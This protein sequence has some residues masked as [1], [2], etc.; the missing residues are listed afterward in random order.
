MAADLSVRFGNMKRSSVQRRI[1]IIGSA[2]RFFCKSSFCSV[3]FKMEEEEVNAQV[4]SAWQRNMNPQTC[5]RECVL[6]G[7]VDLMAG[8]ELIAGEWSFAIYI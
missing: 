8:L 5:M 3:I 4:T 7:P 2:K 6:E 1:S